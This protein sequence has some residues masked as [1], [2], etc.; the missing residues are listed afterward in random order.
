MNTALF[1]QRVNRRWQ[2]RGGTNPPKRSGRFT[3][4]GYRPRSATKVEAKKRRELVEKVDRALQA[5]YNIE[6]ARDLIYNPTWMD[7]V[8]PTGDGIYQAPTTNPWIDSTTG[9][10]TGSAGRV[11]LTGVDHGI[12]VSSLDTTAT[13][14]FGTTASDVTSSNIIIN[15][16]IN[17]RTFDWGAIQEQNAR[18]ATDAG[19]SV[20]EFYGAS[21][22]VP[23]AVA[24]ARGINWQT[25]IRVVPNTAVPTDSVWLV[26]D[27]EVILGGGIQPMTDN[28]VWRPADPRQRFR[29]QMVPVRPPCRADGVSFQH[30]TPAELTALS[31]LKKMVDEAG[32]RTYLKYGFVD[33]Q[34]KSGLR[35]QIRRG[36]WHVL[37]RRQGKRVAEL[38]VGLSRR[39]QMPPTD[40][41]I[42]RMIMAECDE[43]ELWRR[44]NVDV[45]QEHRRYHSNPQNHEHME[46]LVA[47]A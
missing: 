13:V 44:A 46:R 24:A 30:C 12:T 47:A 16:T 14:T 35:Y 36:H 6:G 17:Y 15:P 22:W 41:V 40:E 42:A 43:P 38:C 45:V 23:A 34:G 9:G 21:D 18:R 32:W 31:L 39:S 5:H 27:D 26:N 28:W 11:Y 25:N 20:D 8:Y 10:C 4:P 7:R 19:M 33:V 3:K 1:D 29:Q 2:D 37:V